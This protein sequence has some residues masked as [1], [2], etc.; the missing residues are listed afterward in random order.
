MACPPF[1]IGAI[2]YL[3][4]SPIPVQRD[5]MSRALEFVHFRALAMARTS[6]LWQQGIRLAGLIRRCRVGVKPSQIP[7]FIGG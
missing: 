4:D 5:F 2:G 3:G 7:I 1:A 6:P